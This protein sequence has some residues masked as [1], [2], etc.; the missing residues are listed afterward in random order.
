[1]RN[2]ETL[3]G[4]I[5]DRGRKSPATIAT[6]PSTRGVPRGSASRV[7]ARE[8]RVPGN[9]PA[10]FGG[11]PSEKARTGGTSPAAHPTESTCSVLG[12]TW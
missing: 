1:M 2:A 4:I 12:T 10:R 3:L 8:S 5:R 6:S 11:R 9:G 7:E